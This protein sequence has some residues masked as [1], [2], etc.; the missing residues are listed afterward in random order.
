MGDPEINGGRGFG[1]TVSHS[2]GSQDNQA[3]V[4]DGMRGCKYEHVIAA[5]YERRA[6]QAAPLR[7]PF[8]T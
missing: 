1:A 5:V 4:G 2:P 7:T 8:V 3:Q 6:Q